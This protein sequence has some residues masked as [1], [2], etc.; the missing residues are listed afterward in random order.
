MYA[1][2]THELKVISYSINLCYFNP[3]ITYTYSSAIVLGNG[4]RRG[5]LVITFK[6]FGDVHLITILTKKKA[7][8]IGLIPIQ[9]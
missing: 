2:K 6:H 8:E 1:S 9:L 3:M 7:K 4:V 5:R